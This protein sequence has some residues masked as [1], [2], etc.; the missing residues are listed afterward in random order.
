VP[1][2]PLLLWMASDDLILDLV[3][4]CSGKD[5]AGEKLVLCGVRAT[6]DD[7]LG[8]GIADSGEGLELVG[9]SSVD[10]ERCGRSGRCRGCLGSLSDGKDRGNS[11]EESSGKEL[12][13]KIEHRRISLWDECLTA[14]EYESAWVASINKFR[15]SLRFVDFLRFRSYP[16]VEMSMLHLHHGHHHHH[17]ESVLAAVSGVAK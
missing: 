1:F 16:E 17:A 2:E 9:R 8:V 15:A 6:V 3:I 11:K 10:V 13:A 14:E 7:A 5:T 4:G 12:T